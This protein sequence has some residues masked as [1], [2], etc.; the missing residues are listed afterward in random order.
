MP[1]PSL[2]PLTRKRGADG[3]ARTSLEMSRR[4]SRAPLSRSSL[5][6]PCGQIY[7]VQART[8]QSIKIGFSKRPEARLKA[9]ATGAPEPIELLGSIVGTPS[10]ERALHKRFDHLR[11][12]GE[13]FENDPELIGY[14]KAVLGDRSKAILTNPWDAPARAYL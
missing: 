8:S 1:P 12:S 9:L 6:V 14:I 13:W 11:I 2:Q 7:F 5:P 10:A 3:E 4:K